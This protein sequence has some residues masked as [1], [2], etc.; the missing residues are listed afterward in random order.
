[1]KFGV[2]VPNYGDTCSVEGLKSV[3]I[4]A[5]RLGYHSLWTTD[6]VLMPKKSE[7]PY[8]RIFDSVTTLAYLSSLTKKI[9]LGISSLI[10]AMRNPVVVAKQLVTM[11][12]FSGGRIILA[13]SSGWNE[14]EFSNL[15]SDFHTRGKRVDESIRLIRAL[16][17]GS[18]SF[19]GEVLAQRFNDIVFDPSP[20]QEKLTIWIGGVSK[21]AMRRAAALGDAWHPNIAPLPQFKQMVSQ[22]R[23]TAPQAIDKEICGR[24]ALDSKTEKSYY[25][26][27]HGEKR[28]ILSGNSSENRK[29][30]DELEDLGVSHLVVAPNY[31][32]KIPIQDQLE[33]LKML[34]EGF[35]SK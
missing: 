22:F 5:E 16:W 21:A 4:E 9:S 13:T 7:T 35:I 6:H 15:G 2:C 14:T 18:T 11:D 32:G 30:I 31:N 19:K 17:S 34:S 28:I 29:I 1:M 24:I 20:V 3:S 12:N 27:P 26:S 33:G 10:V 25:I 8:E 23:S